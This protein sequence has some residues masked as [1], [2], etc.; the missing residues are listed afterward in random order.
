MKQKN[1]LPDVIIGADTIVELNNRLFGKPHDKS[2]AIEFLK[3]LVYIVNIVICIYTV[4]YIQVL[5]LFS[6]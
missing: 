3:T 5:S 4:T 6:D 1:N 2:Q